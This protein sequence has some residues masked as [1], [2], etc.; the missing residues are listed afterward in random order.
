MAFT[1]FTSGTTIASDWLNDVN[2]SVYGTPTTVTN[3]VVNVKDA[4]YFA[5][6]N[7]DTDDTDAIQSAIYACQQSGYSLYLPAGTY[8]TTNTLTITTTI[9]I[10]GDGARVS[11]ISTSA[12]IGVLVSVPLMYGNTFSHFNDFG[13]EPQT[14]GAGTSGFKCALT[15]ADPNLN[16]YSYMSNFVVE[17]IYIGDFGSF[18]F[19]LDNSVN[20]GNGFFT[21]SIRRCWISNGMNLIKIGDSCNIEENTITNGATV[22]NNHT[23]GRP[24]VLYTGLPGARQVVLRSNNITTSGGAIVAIAAEQLRIEN[25]QCEHPFYYYNPYGGSTTA[26]YGAFVY[27]YNCVGTEIR[28]NTLQTGAG[29]SKV[30]TGTTNSSA[31]VTGVSA[32]NMQNYVFVGCTVGGS[33]I[34][35]G[36]TV[37]AVGATSFT[38]SA[39][40]STSLVGTSLTIGYSASYAI[41]MEGVGCSYNVVEMND[42]FKGTNY[43]LGLNAGPGVPVATLGLGNT[44][45]A[46]LSGSTPDMY[47]PYGNLYG[48]GLP[49]VTTATL[50]PPTTITGALVYDT[51]TS[52]VKMSNGVVWSQLGGNPA[53]T[54]DSIFVN[55]LVDLWTTNGK[56]AGPPDAFLIGGTSTAVAEATIVWPANLTATSIKYTQNN[57]ALANAL[58][59][60]PAN[61]P[62]LNT[63][64]LSILVPLYMPTTANRTMRLYASLNGSTI[65]L[66]EVAADSTWHTVTTSFNITAGNTWGIYVAIFNPV[67][68]LF[69]STGDICY[70][71]GFNITRGSISQASLSDSAARRAYVANNVTYPPPFLGARAYVSGTGK[72]Y[73]AKDSSTN[74]DWIIL[75]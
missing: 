39:P 66:A 34:P 4:P 64:T 28:G 54:M 73:M 35:V 48:W 68:G 26:Y 13:I 17:R 6:G 29:G 1:T 27:L 2:A 43:H 22:N 45:E 47:N 69:T 65:L 12:L 37:I 33:G 19:V 60:N 10:Y 52:S 23:G 38:M 57:A 25:N 55:S 62:W 75:N 9:H 36:T 5:V 51:T 70:V 59:A 63:E 58:Y 16:Q 18:G 46:G 15:L 44:W 32:L 50:P 42:V 49:Q 30:V 3:G 72:W 21:F 20:N 67:T 14:L 53:P 61:Q 56:V 8:K 31:S 41:L 7:N 11:T 24:G 74:A 71:G 40:S